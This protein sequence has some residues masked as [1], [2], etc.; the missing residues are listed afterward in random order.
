GSERNDLDGE[1]V[2]G[3]KEMLDHY[4][5]LVKSFRMARERLNQPEH[6][7]VKMRLIGRRNK[8]GR[9]YNLP[10]TSKVAALVVGDFDDAMGSRDIIVENRSGRLQRINE[11]NASYLALHYPILYPYGED[12]YREDIPFSVLK[13]ITKRSR[14]FISSLEFF[15]YRMHDRDNELSSILSAR[16]LYQQFVV[17]A[18][19]MVEGARLRYICFNQTKLRTELYSRLKDAVLRGDIDPGS[20]G[21]RIILPS[22]F[23]GGARYMIENYQDAMAICRWTGYPDIFLTFTCNPKW[24]EIGRFLDNKNLKPEDR[25]DIVCRVFKAKLDALMRDARHNKMFGDVKA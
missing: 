4:N 16:R 18:Y 11:L 25:P 7:E 19:T 20:Q 24:P 6:R 2:L 13:S 10:S 3:L 12:G 8:D 15:K 1:V 9:R 14:K 23:T 21:I 5:V 17:D 22:S